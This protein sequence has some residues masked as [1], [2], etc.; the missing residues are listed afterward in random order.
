MEKLCVLNNSIYELPAV[1][2]ASIILIV[3][4]RGVVSQENQKSE[5]KSITVEEG[6]TLFIAANETVK[7]EAESSSIIS[8]RAQINLGNS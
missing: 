7:I 3:Q 4:G 5:I 1:P 6:T 8:F 2:C